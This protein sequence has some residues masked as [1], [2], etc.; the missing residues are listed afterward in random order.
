[1]GEL[2]PADDGSAAGKASTGGDSGNLPPAAGA[3]STDPACDA[4]RDGHPAEG[5]CAGDDCDDTDADVFTK[6][7]K[8]FSARQANVGYDYD[9]SGRP[10]QEQAAAVVCMGLDLT[11]CSSDEG[12]LRT[13]PVCGAT[14]KWGK[15][16]KGTLTCD[17]QV[18]DDMRPMKCH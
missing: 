4:D 2:P 6:Q 11:A 9:C 3:P 15:C 8:Y 18:I 16:V 17:E 12:F 1:V 14:G 13:L 10:Q 5:K 7:P